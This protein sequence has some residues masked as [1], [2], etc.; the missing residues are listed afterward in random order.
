MMIL[1]GCGSGHDNA[2][3]IALCFVVASCWHK[4]G[5]CGRTIALDG[6]ILQPKSQ[7]TVSLGSLE[8][9]DA[10]VGR[11]IPGGIW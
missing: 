7:T 11:Y 6:R 3:A 9:Q 10:S 5:E 1:E 2:I 8:R 4:S